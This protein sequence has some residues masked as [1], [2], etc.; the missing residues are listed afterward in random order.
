[1]MA[2][3]LFQAAESM[4]GTLHGND[5]SF[6]GVST[7]TRSLKPGQLFVAL[8]GPNFDGTKFVRQAAGCKAAGAV[9]GQPVDTD[10]PTADAGDCCWYYRQ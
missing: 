2:G 6:R 10:L 1:M 4:N 3:T 7:D 9:V 5:L 8:Q